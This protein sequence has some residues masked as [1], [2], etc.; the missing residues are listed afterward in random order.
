MITELIVSYIARLFIAINK[1]Q[2]RELSYSRIT[3]KVR[4]L[5]YSRITNK[6]R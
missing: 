3:N 4:E 5:S 1:S 6:V 2:A